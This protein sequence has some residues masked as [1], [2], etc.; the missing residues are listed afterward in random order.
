M[1]RLVVFEVGLRDGLLPDA[2]PHAVH[3]IPRLAARRDAAPVHD[4]HVRTE[5]GDVLHDVR[6]EDHDHVLPDLGEEVVEAVALLGVQARRRLVHDDEPGVAEQRLRD[7]EALAHPAGVG[8]GRLLA[9][10][11]EVRLAQQGLDGRAALLGVGQP[12]EDGEV[13]QELDGGDARVHA[14]V[15][16]QVAELAAHGIGVREH[17]DAVEGHAARVRVLQRRD[18]P[19][20]RRLA[21]PVGA[22][23]PEHA[24]PDVEADPVQGA[25]A[26]RVGLGEAFDRQHGGT[27]VV[28]LRRCRVS[29]FIGKEVSFLDKEV[30]RRAAKKP[31]S[32]AAASSAS[33]PPETSGLWWIVGWANRHGPCA[34]APPF[35]S[36]AA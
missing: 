16:R 25:H 22:E 33:R 26:V 11:P 29:S 17:V 32:S 30:H 28:A 24:D 1:A 7:A 14:E 23:K 3:Q 10:V 4:R 13:V 2:A 15:L 18:R 20:Q 19:H 34:T 9:H 5:V 8:S 6:R 36:G 35:E 27:P 31:R 12:L 21:R